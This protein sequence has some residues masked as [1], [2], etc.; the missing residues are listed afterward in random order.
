MKANYPESKITLV[1]GSGGIFDV[2]CDDRL[3]FSKHKI[4][5]QRFPNEGEI[6]SLIK[7]DMAR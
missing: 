7:A 4:K 5:G 1:K 6:V 2:K 3:I